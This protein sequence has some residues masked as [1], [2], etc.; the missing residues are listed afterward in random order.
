M[1]VLFNLD[2]YFERINYQGATSPTIDVLHA[3]TRAHSQSI[4]FE[5]LDVLLRRPISLELDDIYRKLVIDRRGGYCFE[6]NN[7][8][9]E[10]LKRLG[11]TVSPWGARVRLR[12][13]DRNVLPVRTHIFLAVEIDGEQWI[14]DSGVGALSLT[15][16]LRLQDGGEQITPHETRRLQRVGESWFHQVVRDGAWIDVCEFTEQ[17]MPVSDQIVANWYTS[18]HPDSTFMTQLQVALAQD[19]GGRITLNNS[20]L[21]L[22]QA[23]GTAATYQVA[24]TELL[25]VL[26]E[27][28]A[29]KLPADA[30]ISHITRFLRKA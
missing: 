26:S 23:D 22:R 10:V 2:S 9:L 18:S 13:T 20:E 21:K 6:Q 16:A 1:S 12:V 3:L 28:F 17:R 11:F 7:L 15:Q 4:P 8:L 5:N 25:N 24:D 29:I 27:Y 14:V 30:D 19:N